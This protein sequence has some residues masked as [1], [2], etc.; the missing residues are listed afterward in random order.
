MLPVPLNGM[1]SWLS[2]M[3]QIQK[4][5]SLNG[6]ENPKCDELYG[7]S[8]RKE[9]SS[10]N[11]NDQSVTMKVLKVKNEWKSILFITKC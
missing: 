2:S 5:L 7:S 4:F 11:E 8:R 1:G 6:V 9:S 10:N 3:L